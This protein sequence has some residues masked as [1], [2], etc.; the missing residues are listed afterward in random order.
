MRIDFTVFKKI[1]QWYGSDDFEIGVH[2][3]KALYIRF[4]YW[5][6]VDLDAFNSFFPDYIATAE[7][8]VDEDEDTGAAY[9]YLIHKPEPIV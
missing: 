6:K 1:E 3:D 7:Y 8:L 5:D 9:V 2:S 4:G